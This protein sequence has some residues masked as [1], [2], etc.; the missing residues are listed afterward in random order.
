M[1]GKLNWGAI[2]LDQPIPMIASGVVA[3]VILGVIAWI[4]LAGTVSHTMPN[5]I[6]QVA[7]GS[8]GV[9]LPNITDWFGNWSQ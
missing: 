6:V 7:L 5:S 9:E 1:L 4:V 3:L 2:P 8:S